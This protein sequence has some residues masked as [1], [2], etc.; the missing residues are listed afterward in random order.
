MANE[1]EPRS[2]AAS[3]RR[4][5]W[6]IVMVSIFEMFFAALALSSGALGLAAIARGRGRWMRRTDSSLLGLVKPENLIWYPIYDF[7]LGVALVTS[8][9]FLLRLSRVGWVLLV[10]I[11]ISGIP[12]ALGNFR[13]DR[14]AY[15]SV[16]LQDAALLMWAAARIRVY[17]PLSW[18]FAVF[19]I[20]EPR[21]CHGSRQAAWDYFNTIGFRGC[22]KTRQARK[23]LLYMVFSLAPKWQ[24]SS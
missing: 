24:K 4:R 13:S 7:V 10:L 9:V 21:N 8:A 14:W 22:A 11:A 2:S 5:T 1:V 12:T 16:L 18:T 6:D 17:R 19:R 20:A 3:S 23:E 15:A